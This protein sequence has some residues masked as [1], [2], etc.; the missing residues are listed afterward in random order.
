MIH[1][2]VFPLLWSGSVSDNQPLSLF[3]LYFTGRR[4]NTITPVVRSYCKWVSYL[5]PGTPACC[6]VSLQ[7]V[8]WQVGGAVHG[9]DEELQDCG[10]YSNHSTDFGSDGVTQGTFHSHIYW[11]SCSGETDFVCYC[12]LFS[13]VCLLG[14]RVWS[15]DPPLPCWFSNKDSTCW[16]PYAVGPS[17]VF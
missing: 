15:I 5:W 6:W 16:W 4:L 17:S 14:S 2:S 10:H 3:R 1:V 12:R 8:R 13:V 9:G 11:W 7:A